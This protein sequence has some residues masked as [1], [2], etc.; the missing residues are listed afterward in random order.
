MSGICTDTPVHIFKH[1]LLQNRPVHNMLMPVHT[2][3]DQHNI[4]TGSWQE[5]RLRKSDQ[6][7]E[8]TGPKATRDSDVTEPTVQLLLNS[9]SSSILYSFDVVSYST[10]FKKN[11]YLFRCYVGLGLVQRRSL[12]HR[13]PYSSW[14]GRHCSTSNL[15]KIIQL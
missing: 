15:K 5:F 11:R 1:I 12:N 4:V 3:E 7:L 6:E 2:A 10:C 13:F 9:D 8:R 14:L